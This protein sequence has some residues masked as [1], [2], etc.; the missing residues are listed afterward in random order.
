[1]CDQQPKKRMKSL[2]SFYKKESDVQAPASNINKTDEPDSTPNSL[3]TIEVE[4]LVDIPKEQC[5]R[6]APGLR[7]TFCKFSVNQQDRIRKE[8]IQLGP[9]QPKLEN[10]PPTFD[11]HDNRRFQYRW[12]SLFSWLE[13]SVATDKVFCFPCFVFEKNPPK[14]PLFTT[15]GCNNWSKMLARKKGICEQYVG[16][17]NSF[18]Q[19]NVQNWADLSRTSKHIDRVIDKLRPK[20]VKEN[21]LRL[22]TTIIA[23]KYLGK[24]GRPFRGHDECLNSS[25]RGHFIE[26]FRSYAGLNEEILKVVL[27]NALKHAIY[28]A[29]SIQKEYLEIIATK[30]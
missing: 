22:K 29:P 2:F 18:H 3:P 10:Y 17:L 21:K 27:E 16:Q 25:S 28:I 20:I 15:K 23:V 8:Y 26:I 7:K 24:E 19:K 9:C 11:G 6:T 30:I 12:F 14:S 4:I 5:V 13:Y 1:M